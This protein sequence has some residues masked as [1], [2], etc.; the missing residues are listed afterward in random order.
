METNQPSMSIAELDAEVRAVMVHYGQAAR[1]SD[2]LVGDHHQ[3]HASERF[4]YQWL[5]SFVEK[6]GT[7]SHDEVTALLDPTHLRHAEAVEKHLWLGRLLAVKK[8][9][10]LLKRSM[11]RTTV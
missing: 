5:K 8:E 11:R 9:L 2:T 1:P 6:N 10:K 3:R 7:Y 4:Y